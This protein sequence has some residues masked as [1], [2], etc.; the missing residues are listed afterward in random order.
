M[1]FL[2]FC[3][4][5]G[6]LIDSLPRM[7]VWKRYPTE[8]HP[9]KRNGAVKFMGDHGFIQNHAVE[10]EV[11]LW[12]SDTPNDFDRTKLMR[13]V[14]AAEEQTA[15]RQREAAG[16]AAWILSQCKFGKHD[17]LKAKGFADEEANVWAH[18]GRQTLVIPMRMNGNLLGCQLIDEYGV[19]KFLSGQKTAGAE[20]IFD[21]KGDHILCEGYATALSVRMALK[22]LK[23]RYTIHVCFSA[24][25][26]VKVANSLTGGYIIAD[27]DESGTG[28]RV[29]KQIGWTYFMPPDVGDDFNDFHIKNGLFKASMALMKSI[30]I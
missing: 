13:D 27:N 30:R 15:R 3:K 24:G 16:K 14:R 8:D 29:A 5:H 11:S 26:M 7:G 28:E 9:H 19:K 12:K 23:K 22:S 2:T 18:E 21:N 6:I 17:Y 1:D 25:N 10:T 20:F 4:L